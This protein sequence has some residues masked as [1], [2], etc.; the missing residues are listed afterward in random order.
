MSGRPVSACRRLTTRATPS[1][2]IETIGLP[3]PT[4]L[5]NQ[6]ALTL[7]LFIS[8]W[9]E[10]IHDPHNWYQPYILG[11]YG[12]RQSLPADLTEQ[13]KSQ[14]NAGVAET[15]PAKRAEIYAKLNQEIY[16][17]APQIILAIAT[18]RHYEQRWVDGYFYN[19]I[20]GFYYYA[21]SKK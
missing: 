5:R 4:F 6:R 10:D 18:G 1:A 3:W 15:D 19:P 20:L 8:G 17:A 12:R 7:P 2:T 16:D 14:I 13:F 9:I 11:T 21:F